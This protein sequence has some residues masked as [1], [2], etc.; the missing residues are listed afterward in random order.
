MN[1]SILTGS[2]PEIQTASRRATDRIAEVLAPAFEQQRLGDEV[3]WD[4]ALVPSGPGSL[5]PVVTTWMP[6]PVL[7]E[8]LTSTVPV[9]NPLRFVRADADQTVAELLR[10]LREGRTAML[11][12][13][14]PTA[15]HEARVRQQVS[16]ILRAGAGG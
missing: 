2:A 6:S 10:V 4:V 8:V 15:V 1:S 13:K 9:A 3:V 16:G 14:D 12:G 7:G 5:T 11:E